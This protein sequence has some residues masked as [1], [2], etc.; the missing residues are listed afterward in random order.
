[1]ARRRDGYDD[2]TGADDHEAHAGAGGPGRP[3]TIQPYRTE[4]PQADVDD[5]HRRLASARWPIAIGA[6]DDWSRGVPGAYLRQLADY[7]RTEF[8]WRRQEAWL[9]SFPQF[10]SDIDGHR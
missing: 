7:W 6:P 5:L 4:I 3:V 8:D 9:N 2:Q 10:T 1:H